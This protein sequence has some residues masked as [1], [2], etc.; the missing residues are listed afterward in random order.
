MTFYNHIAFFLARVNDLFT[1]AGMITKYN[2]LTK[3]MSLSRTE[4]QKLRDQNLKNLIKHAYD[5]TTYYRRVFDQLNLTPDDIKTK[6]DL[7]KLPI[8]TKDVIRNNYDDLIARGWESEAI[9]SATGGSTGEP[10]KFA[11]TKNMRA[12]HDAAKLRSWGWQGYCLGDKSVLIWGSSFDLKRLF[13]F[14]SRLERFLNRQMLLNGHILSDEICKEY[15]K[16]IKKFKP[17]VIIGY[18]NSLYLLA[19]YMNENSIKIQVQS[20]ISRAETLFEYQTEEI[21]KAFNCSVFDGYASRETSLEACQ[22]E[23][24]G[25]YYISEDNT[26]M[27][28]V[29]DKGKDVGPEKIGKI[30]LTDLHNYSMPFIRYQIEDVGSYTKKSD[31]LGSPLPLMKRIEGRVS[32]LITLKNGNIITPIYL[33]YLLYPNPNQDWGVKKEEEIQGIKQ[34]QIV[35]EDYLDFTIKIVNYPNYEIKH[36]N[37]ISDNFKKFI[38]NKVEVKVELYDEIPLEVS[39]KRKYVVSKI[40]LKL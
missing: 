4:F 16:K 15:V 1:G 38:D 30:I 37:Y 33:M 21:K 19:N 39:G 40:K 13:N 6:Q 18:A 31:T 9:Q 36:F 17:K 29:D 8:L 12:W 28:F 23:E 25:A 22:R 34:Y 11:I 27:E 32:D 20:V 26:I 2:V 7:E 24:G 3:N 5:N 35:Q 14:K 10:M